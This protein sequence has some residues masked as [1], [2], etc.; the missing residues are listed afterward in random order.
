M[1]WGQSPLVLATSHTSFP[2]PW[3]EG[4]ALWYPVRHKRM[5]GF[6]TH[7]HAQER[8]LVQSPFT[9]TFAHMDIAQPHEGQKDTKKCTQSFCAHSGTH[10]YTRTHLELLTHTTMY[11][12]ARARAHTRPLPLVSAGAG[13]Q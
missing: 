13:G 11:K 8:P 10:T 5:H 6:H 2:K 3:W 7:G 1:V 9:H 4:V 12:Y